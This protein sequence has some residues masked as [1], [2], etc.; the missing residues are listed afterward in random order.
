MKSIFIKYSVFNKTC[1]VLMCVFI[2]TLLIST[3]VAQNLLRAPESVVYDAQNNRYLASNYSTG[4]IV[5]IDSLGN[6]DYFVQNE[7]CKNGVHIEGNIIYAACIDQ[8]VKGFDLTT[9]ELVIHINIDGMINLNDITSD[10]SGNLY[11]SDVYGSK[12]YR[13]KIS[14]YSYTTF[15]DCGSIP[16]NGLY[17]DKQRNRILVASYATPSPIQEINLEDSTIT[18]I[19]NTGYY[20][21][22]GIT[23]DNEGNIYFSTWQTN[24][25]YMYDSLFS[26]PPE[27]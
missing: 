5:A 13:I 27:L 17:F 14:D 25:V 15:V 24:S 21:L 19:V 22:D 8:G 6:H 20:H 12:I 10:T 16:P 11:V 3:S 18:T 1:I 9:E 4:H 26:N 7:Y 23:Q 2:V